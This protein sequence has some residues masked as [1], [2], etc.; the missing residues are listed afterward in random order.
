MVDGRSL[1]FTLAAAAIALGPAPPARAAEP[2]VFELQ[3][4]RSEVKI[5]VGRGGLLKFAGHEHEVMAP[6]LEGEVAADLAEPHRSSVRLEF[7]AAA[8]RVTGRGEPPD[9]L[10]KVQE[11]MAGP[12]VLD[13]ARYPRISFRSVS[14]AG[15]ARGPGSYELEVDGL[16]SLHGV[17]KP[18][19]MPVTVDLRGDD[20][21]ARATFRFKL[22]AF[23][24]VPVSFAG[25]VKVKDELVVECVFRGRLRPDQA[26][27][28]S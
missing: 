24:M 20:L 13:V 17:E 28:S 10:P 4:A 11:T 25:V 12:K 18:L 3:P 8:V 5:Q 6:L 26:R 19:R 21:E 2:L 16:L 7:D 1:A 22:T 15:R 14:V 23:G 9:D 27:T